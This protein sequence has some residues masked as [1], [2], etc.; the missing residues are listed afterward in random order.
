V[1]FGQFTLFIASFAIS[2]ALMV[3]APIMLGAVVAGVRCSFGD[4]D[5]AW[6]SYG[7]IESSIRS[8]LLR[9]D[10]QVSGL[11]FFHKI[12]DYQKSN[13]QWVVDFK[14]NERGPSS[15]FV[16]CTGNVR[17]STPTRQPHQ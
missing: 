16:S 12:D 13:K 4:N 17:L 2:A 10:Y 11:M 14:T 9:V 15:A 3:F 5:C 8:E 1:K 6:N 7:K